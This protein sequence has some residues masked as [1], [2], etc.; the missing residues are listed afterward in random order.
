MDY[1]AVLPPSLMVFLVM[2][3]VISRRFTA[4]TKYFC[5]FTFKSAFT[6]SAHLNFH[7]ELCRLTWACSCPVSSSSTKGCWWWW[8][9]WWWL[10]WTCSS[11]SS[12]SS[13]GQSTRSNSAQSLPGFQLCRKDWI[14]WY[15]ATCHNM[16]WHHTYDLMIILDD[17]Q[18]IWQSP[19]FKALAPRHS[20]F[21]F[22]ISLQTLKL[23]IRV[24]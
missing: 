21:Y 24:F 19:L 14:T 6:F 1:E 7:F 22:V 15:D 4:V 18:L 10:T 23:A 12:S 20:E 3:M 16:I 17:S 13:K 11:P 8:W 2:V 5:T 9:W